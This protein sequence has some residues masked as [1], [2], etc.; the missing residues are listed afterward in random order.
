MINKQT[1]ALE[2]FSKIGMNAELAAENLN[3]SLK[4]TTQCKWNFGKGAR[5]FVHDIWFTQ[6]NKSFQF[7]NAGSPENNDFVFCPFCGKEIIDTYQE[8]ISAK[9]QDLLDDINEES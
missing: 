1:G 3:A 8:K 2:S 4:N 9:L 6:C 7:I 5:G